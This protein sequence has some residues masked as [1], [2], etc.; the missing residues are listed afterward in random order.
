MQKRWFSPRRYIFPLLMAG[1]AFILSPIEFLAMV[2]KVGPGFITVIT[3]SSF[4]M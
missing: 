3:P 4:G 1:E 2:S